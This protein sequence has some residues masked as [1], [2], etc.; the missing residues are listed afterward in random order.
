MQQKIRIQVGDHFF[1]ASLQE[2]P[3]TKSFL[4][5]L[6]F[7]M[8]MHDLNANEKFGDLPK[9]LPTQV[10]VPDGIEAGDIMLFGQNT[11]VLFYRSFRTT[12][13]YTRIGKVDDPKR[14]EAVLGEGDVDV[15]WSE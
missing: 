7:T 2:G 9:N 3:A 5:M 4:K 8:G 11:L 1:T 10:V 12:Y 6:P 14:L 13:G 15:N